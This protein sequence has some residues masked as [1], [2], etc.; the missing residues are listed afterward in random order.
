[1]SYPGYSSIFNYNRGIRYLL[2]VLDV[3]SKYAWVQPLKAKTG[4]ALVHRWLVK[5][6]GWP[7]KYN[8]WIARGDVT[9]L[10]QPKRQRQPKRKE[11]P[12]KRKRQLQ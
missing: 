11:T 8:S 9:S 3:L 6:K 1:M 7:D 2:T 10:R 12:L 4:V 5:W